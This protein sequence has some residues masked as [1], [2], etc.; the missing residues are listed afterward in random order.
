MSNEI[1]TLDGKTIQLIPTDLSERA[2]S[3]IE[4]MKAYPVG[5]EVADDATSEQ[6]AVL[7]RESAAVVKAVEA[8][9][10]ELVR[11]H[12]EWVKS[13]NA[14]FKPVTEA[15]DGGRKRLDLLNA[16]YAKK[17]QDAADEAKRIERERQAALQA[18]RERVLAGESQASLEDLIN[19][20]TPTIVIDSV[21]K[22]GASIVYVDEV[23]VIDE[24]KIPRAFVVGDETFQLWTLDKS[25]LLR[26]LKAGAAIKGAKIVQVE[27]VR[28][29][30]R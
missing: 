23:Q 20:G 19:S 16:R 13:V 9:R 4:G 24:S 2:S 18:E 30:G 27:T 7:T 22:V 10:D 26:A 14:G 17:K 6:I 25:A 11:P 29:T 28:R 1:A 12:N 8:R 15:I 21:P 5:F 3:V